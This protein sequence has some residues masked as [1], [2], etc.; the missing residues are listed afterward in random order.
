MKTADIQALFSRASLWQAW[1]DVEAALAQAQA[2]LGMIPAAAAEEIARRASLEAVGEEALAAD[3]ARSK[4]PIASLAKALA[5]VCEGDAGG[6][7]HWGA[8]TQNVM[9]TAITI[10]MRR[11]HEAFSARFD[12]MLAKLAT[13]AE[14]HAETL[15]A[16]RT[17]ERH[18][19][20]ITFGFKVAGWI[21]EFMRHRERFAG[22]EPRVF[23]SL[24]G[25]AVGAMH[26]FGEQGPELNRR[27][28]SRLGLTPLAVPSRSSN[29]YIV[30]YFLLL[31]L[32]SASCSKVARELYGLMADEIAEV[33][34]RQDAAVVGSS[35]MPNKV[36][37][38]V[39]VHAIAV[40]ARLRTLTPLALEA[41]QP[42]HEGDAA[43]NQMLYSLIEQG[44]PLAYELASSM[45]EL[46]GCLG[47]AA[48]NMKRNLDL[49]GQS[50]AAENAMMVLAPAIG[51]SQA[52][53]AL[54]RAI[55]A[56][57][58]QGASVLDALLADDAVRGAVT[59]ETLRKAIDPANYTGQS[60]AMARAMAA[61]ARAAA[62]P[63]PT[64]S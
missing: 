13:L 45:D 9:Q 8:T 34:E 24:W 42:A 50:I 61:A 11:A 20:P 6:Y 51:R 27:L 4:A 19:L 44:C 14:E 31:A 2:E 48:R 1:L 21:E 23:A 40:A 29:D 32:F 5:A 33:Y 39:A 10:Q 55:K 58:Q 63:T 54:K 59:A 57:S 16:G 56:S 38:K 53:A 62:R 37:P 25:G 41:M 36:N 43:S 46:L 15:M 28:S 12:E 30:E 7:V 18:A 22:A 60:A 26:A 35:T 17:N 47:V 49:S 64:R 52:Y 3:I